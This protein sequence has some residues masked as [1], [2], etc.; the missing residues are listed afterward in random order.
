MRSLADL[1][2]YWYERHNEPKLAVPKDEKRRYELHFKKAL[3]AII[4]RELRRQDVTAVRDGIAKKSGGVQSNRCIALVNRVLYFAVD[5]GLT[6]FNSAA[7]TRKAAR[8]D[9]RTRVLSD[10]ELAR[11][12]HELDCIEKWQPHPGTE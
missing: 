8:E 7:R 3:G 10:D 2:A 5:E 12:W 4:A 6:A 9:P 1:F 11:L